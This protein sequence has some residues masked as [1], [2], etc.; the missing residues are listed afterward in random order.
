MNSKPITHTLK[1]RN[2]FLPVHK[3]AP[4]RAW[5]KVSVICQQETLSSQNSCLTQSPKCGSLV[6]WKRWCLPWKD[7][8]TIMGVLAG[9]C[10]GWMTDLHGWKMDLLNL[11][12][13]INSENSIWNAQV[14][15]LPSSYFS[16][17][18]WHSRKFCFYWPN[19]GFP[20]CYP[21]FPPFFLLRIHFSPLLLIYIA[22]WCTVLPCRAISLYVKFCFVYLKMT[23]WLSWHWEELT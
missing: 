18:A 11:L 2:F 10:S 13:I 7:R 5:Q 15:N 17:S 19:W 4:A 6:F 16:F 23:N 14:D 20:S 8:H 22:T 1:I 3:Q 21:L 12:N 9:S